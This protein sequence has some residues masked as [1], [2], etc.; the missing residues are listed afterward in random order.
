MCNEG[1]LTQLDPSEAIW[2][3][4]KPAVLVLPISSDGVTVSP[5]SSSLPS[6]SVT[7]YSRL[8]FITRLNWRR[9]VKGGR[10]S[11]NIHFPLH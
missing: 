6:P 2:S 5:F 3:P 4:M 9:G 7:D 11:A 8:A 10:L 1:V